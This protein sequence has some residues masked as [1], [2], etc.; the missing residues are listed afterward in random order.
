[1]LHRVPATQAMLM[2]SRTALYAAGQ[3]IPLVRGG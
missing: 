1:M 3:A 2:R